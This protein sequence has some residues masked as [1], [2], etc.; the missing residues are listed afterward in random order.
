[1]NQNKSPLLEALYADTNNIEQL[2]ALID[3]Y[4]IPHIRTSTGNVYFPQSTNEEGESIPAVE[5]IDLLGQSVVLERIL[6]FNHDNT[7]TLYGLCQLSIEEIVDDNCFDE[8]WKRENKCIFKTV[9]DNW[10]LN[11]KI[12]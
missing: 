4:G 12:K 5:Y 7:C 9:S 2:K 3:F 6:K 1:V 11:E 10:K 8:Q